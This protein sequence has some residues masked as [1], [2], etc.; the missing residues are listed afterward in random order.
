MMK[1][2]DMPE[3][4]ARN[5]FE[6]ESSE[7]LFDLSVRGFKLYQH[8]RMGLYYEVTKQ[9]N[10]FAPPPYTSKPNKTRI[11]LNYIKHAA[12]QNDFWG[13]DKCK[14]LVVESS[15]RD[16]IMQ[17]NIYTYLLLENFKHDYSVVRRT[18]P[19]GGYPEEK[20]DPDVSI[21]Y[22]YFLLKR[23]I[24]S[25]F[26]IRA[27][28]YD[29]FQRIATKIDNAF[30]QHL[31]SSLNIKNYTLRNIIRG[32]F[33]V[34]NAMNLLRNVTPVLLIVE[35]AYGHS[36][37]VHAAKL[38]K[39]PVVELQHSTIYPYHLGYTYPHAQNGEIDIFPDY[40]LSYGDF[41]KSV[42]AYPID[43]QN[44]IAT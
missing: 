38:Q 14:V 22:D 31:S 33:G 16:A 19:R 28:C 11:L 44:I 43:K 15:R 20:T 24:C 26:A 29:D 37:I 7:G 13:V 8:V 41:W 9:L 27:R 4:I 39:I 35:D 6:A 23:T 2:N 5:I 21:C 25:E 30:K 42:A 3:E 12:L 10:I 18:D 40:I 34:R 1:E 32:Y 36:D 17:K